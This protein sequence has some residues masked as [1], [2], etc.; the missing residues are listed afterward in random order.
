MSEMKPLKAKTI[1]EGA[2]HT[3]DE[4][5]KQGDAM[6]IG[7]NQ[8]E[9]R[10]GTQSYL[11]S[12]ELGAFF[13]NGHDPM[14]IGKG[15]SQL[16]SFKTN[17]ESKDEENSVD[18]AEE[19]DPIDHGRNM[20]VC[21]NRTAAHNG[22]EEISSHF[23]RRSDTKM[24]IHGRRRGGKFKFHHD[25]RSAKLYVQA[26]SFRFPG[27]TKRFN[28]IQ[29]MT[30]DYEK[31]KSIGMTAADALEEQESGIHTQ[32]Q[33]AKPKQTSLPLRLFHPFPMLPRELRNRI[34]E[35][36]LASDKTIIPQLCDCHGSDGEIQFTD[37]NRDDHGAVTRSLNITFTSKQVRDEA[38]PVF[39]E[40]NVFQYDNDLLAYLDYLAR[41]GRFHLVHQVTFPVSL[42]HERAAVKVLGY[43]NKN[44][45][46]QKAFDAIIDS[47]NSGLPRTVG[48]LKMDPAFHIG[49][50]AHFG[51]FHVLRKLSAASPFADRTIV[52]QVPSAETFD[53]SER[54]SWFFK[55]ASAMGLTVKTMESKLEANFR[56]GVIMVDWQQRFQKREAEDMDVGVDDTVV[57]KKA[58]TMFPD[59][60]SYVMSAKS[61]YY[62]V[63]CNGDVQWYDLRGGF[64]EASR[65][66]TI[67]DVE[68]EDQ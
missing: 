66:A 34:Y 39:Y 56:N 59:M 68:M 16:Q 21:V 11:N 6:D 54:S 10:A 9:H 7:K 33:L 62:R 64:S 36:A 25:R 46:A 43:L 22:F 42:F 30:L 27:R 20:A 48:T 40:S 14:D 60:A 18:P 49:G 63:C 19:R 52:L 57:L 45:A 50:Y 2:S 61:T 51:I 31:S 1:P 3:Q 17:M 5:L 26:Q 58:C 41:A 37:A 55:V 53:T 28:R 65:P 4:W 35:L 13:D 47:H 32:F 23:T 67:Q 15:S 29:S 38:L 24:K 12:E 44:I 8:V